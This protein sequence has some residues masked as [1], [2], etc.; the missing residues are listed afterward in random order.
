MANWGQVHIREKDALD[1]FLTE[2]SEIVFELN[3]S[4]KNFKSI[5]FQYA[6]SSVRDR[7]HVQPKDDSDRCA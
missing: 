6:P 5:F 1:F 4:L 3:L 2:K 7:A